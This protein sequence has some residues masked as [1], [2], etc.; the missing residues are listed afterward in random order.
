ML[1]AE[2]KRPVYPLW[3]RNVSKLDVTAVAVTPKNYHQF[4]PRLDWWDSDPADFSSTRIRPKNK[5]VKLNAPENQWKQHPLD[6]VDFFG[7]APGPGVTDP[8]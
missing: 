6:P 7:G 5:K 2:L 4:Q 1:F 8:P 3:T